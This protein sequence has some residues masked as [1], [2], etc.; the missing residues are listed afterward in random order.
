MNAS[1]IL[2]FD[3]RVREIVMPYAQAGFLRYDVQVALAWGVP[4]IV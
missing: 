4:G 2:E 3:A 1:S